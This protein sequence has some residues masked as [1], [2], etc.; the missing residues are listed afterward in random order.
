MLIKAKVTNTFANDSTLQRCSSNASKSQNCLVSHSDYQPGFLEVT[1]WK[2]SF[3]KVTFNFDEKTVKSYARSSDIN[4]FWGHE[5][6]CT[7]D[8]EYN[9]DAK[10]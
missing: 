6:K 8:G 5:C 10:I 3:T 7:A 4:E 2:E 1:V 9:P